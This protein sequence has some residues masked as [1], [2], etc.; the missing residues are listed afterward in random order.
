MIYKIFDTSIIELDVLDE[1]E[2]A[3]GARSSTYFPDNPAFRYICLHKDKAVYDSLNRFQFSSAPM[4]DAIES[5][6]MVFENHTSFDFISINIPTMDASLYGQDKVI[7]YHSK[8][9]LVFYIKDP[10]VFEKV[11]IIISFLISKY[12]MQRDL[13]RDTDFL[14]RV[15]YSFLEKLTIFATDFL[16]NFEEKT[17]DLEA[18]LIE[19]VSSDYIQDI[20]MLR[21][22][23][24]TLKKHYEQLLD[25]IDEIQQ[26]EN[27]FMDDNT[28]KLI[29]IFDAKVERHYHHIL[30][31]RDY[32]TQIREAYQAQIDIEANEIMKVFTVITAVFLPLTLIAGWYGMNL[33]MPEYNSSLA[34]PAIILLSALIFI[35][36]LMY[37]KRKKWF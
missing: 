12:H 2:P 31:L 23:L 1:Y 28:L 18:S 24:F 26:N 4:D 10:S 34:Y 22:D 37:F 15:I 25:L 33:Q 36:S 27:Q 29:K 6:S 30:S 14:N 19:S 16:D 21:K 11:T 17:Y 13:F 9:A 35:A 32:V 8:N 20:I 5:N 3:N 7:I